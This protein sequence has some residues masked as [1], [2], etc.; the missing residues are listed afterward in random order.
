MT[1]EAGYNGSQ[2]Y[3][4]ITYT[5]GDGTTTSETFFSQGPEVA[6]TQSYSR[7]GLT[8]AN[9]IVD[10]S[11]LL[12]FNMEAFRSSGLNGTDYCN[13][14]FH[15]VDANTWKI[16]VYYEI[17]DPC[18]AA[19]SGNLDTDG[20]GVSDLCDEDDD[21]DGI[22]D[23]DERNILDCSTGNNPSFGLAQGPNN[24]NGSNIADPKVGDQFLYTGVYT[25]VDAIVT[26]VSSNDTSINVLDVPGS[27][28]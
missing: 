5:N 7:T 22:L 16:T 11:G 2:Q 12:N 23:T 26:I 27:R 8:I 28:C 25:G 21:N 17:P 14:D 15:K 10:L 9:G 4:K 1:A 18:D 13:T 24:Y 6:G 3:S 19:A 20:D